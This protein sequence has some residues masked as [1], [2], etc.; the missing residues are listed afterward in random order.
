MNRFSGCFASAEA[1]I[2]RNGAREGRGPGGE[3]PFPVSLG[4]GGGPTCVDGRWVLRFD[5]R[6]LVT[7]SLLRAVVSSPVSPPKAGGSEV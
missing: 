3:F 7:A 6:L 2:D 4:C 1:D 5:L